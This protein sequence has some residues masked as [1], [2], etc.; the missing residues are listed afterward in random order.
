MKKILRVII[1]MIVLFTLSSC[2]KGTNDKS[3]MENA[4]NELFKD[5]DIN[6]VKEDL[7][8]IGNIDKVY[9]I[10]QSTNQD[11]ISNEGI[12]NQKNEDVKVLIKITI[13]YKTKEIKKE[14]T[15]NVLSISH[16]Q[17]NDQELLKNALLDLNN[18]ETYSVTFSINTKHNDNSNDTIQMIMKYD[19]NKIS[20]EDEYGYTY[21][22]VY[23]NDGYYGIYSDGYMAYK[24]E[25]SS[26]DFQ[27]YIIN[28]GSFYEL[29]YSDVDY[30]S[31]VFQDNK[32][33][34]KTNANL[35][36][37]NII[38]DYDNDD[39]NEYYHEVFDNVEIIIQEDK[40]KEII[41]HSKLDYKKEN[42]I[43]TDFVTYELLFDYNSVSITLPEI[44]E[45][46][47]QTI[48]EIYE[49]E[50]EM[51]VYI[52][53]NITGLMSDYIFV[54]DD[55]GS[56]TLFIGGKNTSVSFDSYNIG[57]Y[58]EILG[59]KDTYNGLV[60]IKDIT[61]LKGDETKNKVIT[62]EYYTSLLGL[63][64][65]T[66][67][68]LVFNLQNVIITEE[69]QLSG[70]KGDYKFSVSDGTTEMVVFVK[71]VIENKYHSQLSTLKKGD[72]ISIDSI[73]VSNF[74]GPQLMII[75]DS[76]IKDSVGLNLSIDQTSFENGTDI[77]VI[78]DKLV[79]TYIDISSQTV[80]SKDDY[81]VDY[82]SYD[83]TKQGKY[84]L[85]IKYLNFAS[86]IEISVR[87]LP[88]EAVSS[89]GAT[90]LND[91]ARSNNI[92]VGLP[93]SGDVNVLVFP[94]AFTNISVPT[95]YKQMIDLGFNGT[96]QNTG[97]ESL[98]SYYS[99][100]SFGK[101]NI[102][103]EIM[104]Y[105]QTGDKYNEN[106]Q[107]DSELDLKYIEKAIQ[108][109]DSKIDYAKYDQNNDSIIDCI[110]IIYMA[111]YN[112]DDD[113][114]LWWAYTSEYET[115]NVKKYDGLD[116]G[117]YV[118]LSY[119]FFNDPFIFG[120]TEDDDVYI[121]C[122][123]TTLIHET[124]HAFGLD[125]YY[126]YDEKSGPSGGLGGSDMM[127]SSVGD[128]NPYSKLL[129]GWIE[130]IVVINKDY[131]TS[132][133]PYTESGDAIIIAKEWKGSFY[134]EYYIIDF[135][136]PTSLYSDFIDNTGVYSIPGIRIYHVD[137]TL[138]TSLRDTAV[139]DMTNNNNSY[140]SKKL[141]SL[142]EADGNNSIQKGNYTSNSDLFK[143]NTTLSPKWN[144]GSN[145]D[146]VIIINDI[147]TNQ[148]SVTIDFR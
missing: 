14:I 32:Y 20:W 63:D 51:S 26:Q 37:K 8:F 38:G 9:F 127:D 77:E 125:D 83:K 80:L 60:E 131:T 68:G 114:T 65:I 15:F 122:N 102:K 113:D 130:P 116:L 13:I 19:N 146:F 76:I 42:I 85:I 100:S 112:Y 27:D 35:E 62:N 78:L 111:P 36:G 121:A 4:Y 136:T 39:E 54:Q 40:I 7:P 1:I 110:Y 75:E 34:T 138:K 88:T 140:S 57:D 28:Y 61:M 124:G 5:I 12:V 70:T 103:G 73:V 64:A 82:S 25:A 142:I 55:T 84:T 117:Y 106:T 107:Y 101:V 24:C 133:K 53:G 89:K 93:S 98:N 3:I 104:D 126:D 16:G 105:Y 44:Q 148:A 123:A 141:I 17:L 96:K 2:V 18:K 132:L 46:N 58:I 43:Y 94:I 95:N 81:S 66:K 99:K 52:G 119:E 72:F 87:A 118:F 21:Y 92:T 90:K 137:A 49:V 108:Y 115:D 97:Y 86:T 79:V 41:L 143:K 56:I 31:F 33:V 74:K 69:Y 134:S 109:Y 50:D 10:Y 144:D 120:E 30:K 23:T 48:K 45:N 47:N 11:V 128:H 29:M 139:Y 22:V 147:Q 135:Y 67:Q 59:I 91:V 6:N 129:L 145:C 71:A